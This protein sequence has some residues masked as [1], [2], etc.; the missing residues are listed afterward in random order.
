MHTHSTA[1]HALA[2]GPL[3]FDVHLAKKAIVG[4][5]TD[6]TLLIELM[7]GRQ[8]FEIRWLKTAYRL[9]YG[10]DLVDAVKSDLSGTTM[11]S[12]LVFLISVVMQP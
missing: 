3:G 10:K 4:M 5:G 9:R 11:E 6:E 8:A 12:E 1:I 2:L 7:L